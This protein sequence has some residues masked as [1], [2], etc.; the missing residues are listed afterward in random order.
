MH[1]DLPLL[2]GPALNATLTTARLR[3]EPLG[4]RHARVLFDGLREP[5]IYEWISLKPSPDVDHLEARWARVAERSLVAVDV[6]DFG[7]AV[8]RA[9]DGAWIGKMDAEVQPHGVATNIGYAFVPAYWGR[10]YAT[11]AVRALCEH[12]ARHGVVEQRATVTLG[13]DVS[14]R[15]LE[16][17][18]FVRE[19]VIPGNDTL[20]G[21]LVDDV[22]YI[23]R[24]PRA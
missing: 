13:N 3:L 17:A 21:V 22:E 19:R 16:N 20:R 4:G 2:D 5:A 18:G 8:Q 23:R 1:D 14:C 6:L 9:S 15:V 12:L 10:G 11:E 24:D 7:W